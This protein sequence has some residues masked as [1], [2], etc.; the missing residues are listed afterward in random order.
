[1][2]RPT[3]CYKT[4]VETEHIISSLLDICCKSN[5]GFHHLFS[6][7]NQYLNHVFSEGFTLHKISQWHQ[8]G[9]GNAESNYVANSARQNISI[10]KHCS[11]QSWLP[12]SSSSMLTW[13]SAAN[14]TH[15][16]G[17]CCTRRL[18]Q[19]ADKGNWSQTAKLRP[20]KCMHTYF[21]HVVRWFD[22]YSCNPNKPQRWLILQ[23]YRA[24]IKLNLPL[25]RN[26]NGHTDAKSLLI[27]LWDSVTAT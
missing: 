2:V 12:A 6:S 23:S 17:K 25:H 21:N 13:I 16:A 27:W 3:P 24:G 19:H 7:Y 22:F 8:F 20:L 9:T 14:G 10:C 4:A 1:M 15:R 11:S 18:G 26:D 5:I